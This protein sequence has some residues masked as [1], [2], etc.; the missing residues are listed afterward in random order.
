MLVRLRMAD[1]RV[2]APPALA[3]ALLGA[4]VQGCTVGP[5]FLPPEAKTP[6]AW[7]N[8]ALTAAPRKEP[9]SAVDAAS[10]PVPAWWTSFGDPLLTSLI[11][12]A[13]AANLDLRQ[14]V[15]R[16]AEARAQRDIAGAAQWPSLSG[17]ASYARER[18]S[19]KT[20]MASL[21]SAFGAAPGSP[22]AGGVSRALPGL[23]NPFGQYQY[24]FD[25]SWEVDLFG[26]VRRSI[27]AADADAAATV[28]D[29]R[30]VLISLLGEVA[31]TYIDLRGAQLRQSILEENIA[32]QRDAFDLARDRRR[33][34]MGNDLDVAN[35]AAQVTSTQ[36]LLPAV[37]TRII[38]D[39]DE[40]SFLLALEPGALQAEL[41]VAK[42]VPPVPPQVPIG[43]PSALLRRRPDIRNAEAQLHAATARVGFAVADLFPRLTLNANAGFQAQHFGDLSN[44]AGRYFSIGPTLELP[45]F[46]AGQRAA[47]VRLQDTKAKEAAVVYA[48]TVLAALHDVDNALAAYGPEQ[49]RRAS[50]EGTVAQNRDALMLAQDR[51]SSGVTNFLDVLDA[52]RSLQQTELSLADSRMM[53]SID[54][55]ALYKA[56][57]GGWEAPPGIAL[58]AHRAGPAETLEGSH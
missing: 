32:T 17:N 24:G 37:K 10:D 36:A 49:S 9:V 26:R 23:Q 12:R 4:L 51:Y 25:A 38:Q 52:E 39:I 27:E 56:L 3:L 45:I 47:T 57:G 20:A 43:L 48:R 41:A 1:R 7:T 44:W 28:E 54:L 50:L 11:E 42:P 40:L 19:E 34:E 16:I 55:V 13:A 58:D 35:A 18:I 2:I 6:A 29:G 15:L 46:D 14:A 33:A 53:V 22:A 31:R 30:D 8:E 21:L 5:D